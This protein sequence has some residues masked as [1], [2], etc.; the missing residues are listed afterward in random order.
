MVQTSASPV[1]AMEPPTSRGRQSPPKILRACVVQSGKVIE[2]QRLRRRESLSV[3]YGPRNTF[4]IADNSLP[5]THQLFVVKGSQYE[6][7]L[8]EGMRG[9]LSV[10]NQPVDFA[11]LKSQGVLKKKGDFYSLEL[12]DQHRGKVVIGEVTII[13]Q[14]VV[15][16]PAPKR[17]QLPAAARGSIWQKIDWPYTAALLAAFVVEAPI[18]AY[19][20]VAPRPTK[21]SLEDVDDRWADLI[22]PDLKKEEKKE[23]KDEAKGEGGERKQEKKDEDD[24]PKDEAGKAKVA[25][26]RKAKIQQTIAGKG[27]LAILGTTGIGAASGAVADVFGDGGVGGDLDAAFDGITGVGLATGSTRTT[28]GSGS[29]DKASIGG[30]QTSGGGQVGLG[31]KRETR[32]GSVATATPEVDGALDQEAIAKV[33]RARKRMVQ[34]CYERE[35]KRDPT[36]TGRIEIEFTIGPSGAIEDASV[37]SNKM[38]SDAVGDCI[39]SRLRHWRFPKPDGGS[40]TVNFPFIFTPAS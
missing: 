27:M 32:L 21:L 35:L 22:V 12:S 33:V 11:T 19:F 7:V 26:A 6:L 2:E 10:A 8:T 31:G 40:V 37:S 36:L 13:F 17:P 5:K 30:L 24:K 20:Q 34:D 38:G 14:F 18:I 16:P 29:G 9:R 23:P 3:G 25:A 28:R 39:V 1:T 15:P 4:V